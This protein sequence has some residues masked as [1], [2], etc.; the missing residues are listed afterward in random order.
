MPIDN[1]LGQPTPPQQPV[2]PAQ[3]SPSDEDDENREPLFQRN[4]SVRAISDP[5]SGERWVDVV[6]S[7]PEL[8][9]YDE[10]VEQDWILDR[11]NANPVVLWAH[12]SWQLPIG[13]A[14]NVVINQETGNLEM[15]LNFCDE[16]ANPL[17]PQVYESYRQRSL[18]AVSV[19]FFPQSTR[20]E[21]KDG[22]DVLILSRNVLVEISATPIGA[23]PSALAKS[24]ARARER[25][26]AIATRKAAPTPASPPSYPS[27]PTSP[28]AVAKSAVPTPTTP[29]RKTMSIPTTSPDQ[30]IAEKAAQIADLERALSDSRKE[31]ADSRKALADE[32]AKS[33]VLTE[34][35][36]AAQKSLVDAQAQAKVA[37]T[38]A[39]AAEGRAADLERS[40]SEKTA[41]A[42][43]HF[44]KLTEIELSAFV[45]KK[46]TPAEL[47]G[48]LELALA[49]QE[50]PAAR[51]AY[52][53]Q[54]A[55]IKARADLPTAGEK[56][57]LPPVEKQAPPVDAPVKEAPNG[58]SLA[59]L[60]A[61]GND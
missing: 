12:C 4:F 13:S 2:Q 50:H 37:Q 3:R 44:K 57:A 29:H 16:K 33:A 51:K 30:M 39:N 17:G 23:N 5:K 54:V 19:G 43:A 38:K 46:I 27:T 53:A 47:P 52:D 35:R 11:F 24:Y 9:S 25:A 49:A 58:K 40:L 34:E 42:T 32:R 59:D 60:A 26:M 36:D 41:E 45:G 21:K 8:D 61:E 20:W 18:R 1:P 6:A 14:S 10:I 22:K 31:L 55:L 15:R 56:S 7:T 28:A 48:L